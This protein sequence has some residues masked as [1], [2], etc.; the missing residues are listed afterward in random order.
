MENGVWE[1]DARRRD[2]VT[3][4]QRA[5]PLSEVAGE[6]AGCIPLPRFHTNNGGADSRFLSTAATRDFVRR[7]GIFQLF[8]LKMDGQY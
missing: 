6:L 7:P 2:Y 4:R 1:W 5:K 8:L 3:P